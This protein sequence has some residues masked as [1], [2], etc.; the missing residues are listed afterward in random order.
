MV[1]H[2]H[3]KVGFSLIEV[4]VASIVILVAVLAL[5]R[6]FANFLNLTVQA[7]EITVATDD[8]KDTLEYIKCLPFSA[9]TDSLAG[10]FAHGDSVGSTI[11]GGFALGSSENIV[12]TYPQGINADP[13]EIKVEI[14]WTGRG[15]RA[16]SQDFRTIRT[17]Y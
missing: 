12:V 15:G 9:I 13:L 5:C 17:S 14:T 6:V 11:I 1:R 8:L 16:Y 10:G 7:K 3:G 2:Y 4:M